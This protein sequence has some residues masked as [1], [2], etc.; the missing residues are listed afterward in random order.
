MDAETLSIILSVAGLLLGVLS[1]EAQLRSMAKWA[2]K[3]SGD[4][5]RGWVKRMNDDAELYATSSSALVAFIA[6]Q[7]LSIV[8]ILFLA[9]AL[10]AVLRSDAF[11]TPLWIRQAIMLLS[12]VWVGNKLADVSHLVDMTLRNTRGLH[13]N[14]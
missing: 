5:A 1:A 6:K 8:F 13:G 3:T 2:L 11:A 14:G 9:T 7:V 10:L 4:R 12:A